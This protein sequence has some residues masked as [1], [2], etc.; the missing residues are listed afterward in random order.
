MTI[1]MLY[2]NADTGIRVSNNSKY[3]FIKT[4]KISAND[5]LIVYS[6]T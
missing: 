5:V 2:K 4:K 3:A 1:S 6:I